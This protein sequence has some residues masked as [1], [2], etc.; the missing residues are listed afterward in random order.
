MEQGFEGGV[1]IGVRAESAE[2][3]QAFGTDAAQALS[4]ARPCQALG[5][6]GAWVPRRMRVGQC[7]L[8]DVVRLREPLAVRR[9]GP[10]R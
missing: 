2:E 5:S 8:H 10:P 6:A 4:D 3:A 7:A 1:H 9:D